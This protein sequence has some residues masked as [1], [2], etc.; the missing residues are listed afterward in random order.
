MPEANHEVFEEHFSP[1][2]LGKIWG[3]SPDTIRRIFR[4]EPGVVVYESPHGK[5][6]RPYTSIRIPASVAR[7]IHEKL[8]V[9]RPTLKPAYAV[10]PLTA[11]QRTDNRHFSEA[12][13][14]N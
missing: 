1:K 6:K 4:D 9:K 12:E 3:V 5:D 2:Q 10:R 11:L 7:R 13:H 8:S 14:D